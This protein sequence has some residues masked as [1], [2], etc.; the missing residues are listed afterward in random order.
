MGNNGKLE[1]TSRSVSPLVS[2]ILSTSTRSRKDGLT[3][4]QSRN[5]WQS[6]NGAQDDVCIPKPLL[7]VVAEKAHMVAEWRRKGKALMDLPVSNRG[8]TERVGTLH[9]LSRRTGAHGSTTG[10]RG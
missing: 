3:A 10:S 5:K 8:T 2:E 1:E 7:E 6:T 4:Y 9:D